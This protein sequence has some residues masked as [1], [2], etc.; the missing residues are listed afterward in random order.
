MAAILQFKLLLVLVAKRWLYKITPQV[1]VPA[2]RSTCSVNRH[3]LATVTYLK[4][5]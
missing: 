3:N 1:P 2:V 4:V 5:K